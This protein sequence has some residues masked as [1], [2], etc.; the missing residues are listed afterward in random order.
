MVL[1]FARVEPFT[2]D[3]SWFVTSLIISWSVTEV[4]RYSFYACKQV[5]YEPFILIYLRYT[6]FIILYLTG[7][8]SEL[9]LTYF[10]LSYIQKN[11][12]YSLFMPNSYNWS[13]DTFYLTILTFASYIYGF[14]M[15]Y[16]YM[17]VQR[18]KALK[19]KKE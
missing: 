17:W 3:Q 13:F 14:P 19:Q 7:V 4:I 8:G 6:T 2:V 9:I 18:A 16:K 11:R 1:D 12:P 15:L 5:D 10:K